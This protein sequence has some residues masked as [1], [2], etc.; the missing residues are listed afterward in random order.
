MRRASLI[1]GAI[2]L[3]VLVLV[4]AFG[5][6]TRSGRAAFKALLFVPA[7][8]PAIEVPLQEF[9]TPAPLHERVV[10]STPGGP[11][12][13][14]L[15]R[16]LGEGPFPAVLL[17]LG[18]APAGADDPRVV[19]LGDALARSGMAVLWYW[20]PSF[21]ER[22]VDGDEIDNLVAAFHYLQSR[23]E[24]DAERVGMGGFCVGASFVLVASAQDA[25]REE[26]AF[27]NAF[28]PYFDARDLVRAIVSKTRF[29]EGT[30][31]T[32][33]WDPDPL[34][35]EVVLRHLIESVVDA[36]EAETLWQAYLAGDEE[37]R[38][39]AGLSPEAE[40][41]RRLLEG[42]SLDAVDA[43]IADLPSGLLEDL[44]S[45]SPATYVDRIAAPVL[46]MHDRDD[47]LVPVE[48][49]QRLTQALEDR[50]G[51]VLFTEFTLFS[52]VTPEEDVPLW[53]L[54]SELWKFF[55]HMHGIML[56][57]E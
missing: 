49:S 6:G 2:A 1:L 37:L 40:S 34:A 41:V 51:S 38:E 14:D 22:R 33:W 45:V 17:F 15:Y 11:R 23:S 27:V 26:V 9:F 7:V 36:A 16:P 10:F 52:H 32:L 35:R 57:A 39:V 13:G 28:G 18:V 29:D 21:A 4:S 42:G 46:V 53:T 50:G 48:E 43:Q 5:F 20:S 3:L 56:Q 55:R 44:A 30:R 19:D 25:V 47:R 54:A 31:E 24:V 8:V 12:E